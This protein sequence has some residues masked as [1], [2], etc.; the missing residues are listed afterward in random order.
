[1][2][3]S[4][5]AKKTTRKTLRPVRPNAGVQAWYRKKLTNLIT[6][7]NNSVLYWLGAEWNKTALPSLALD[8]TPASLMRSAVNRLK[9]RWQ[10][11]F[12]D[13]AKTL[14]RRLT[15]QTLSNSDASLFGALKEAGF[16]VKFQMTPVMDNAYQS[17]IGQQVGLIRSIPQQYLTQVETLVMQSV[18]RGRDLETLTNKLKEQYG[19]TRRRAAFIALDQNN[20]ATA[21]LQAARQQSLG[22]TKGIW[23]HSHAAKT[24]R[25]SHLE[26]DGKEFDLSK[27]LFLEG[28]WVLPGQAI[29]CRCGWEV[30]IPSLEEN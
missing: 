20:K 30:V 5:R 1:M 14:S 16:T 23:R 27:G 24:P 26:A 4:R 19:I 8:A 22:M 13:L 25:P 7:M 28:E 18:T 29:N 10:R 21:T 9:N 17:V 6:E 11:K 12:D 15:E 3:R 2:K